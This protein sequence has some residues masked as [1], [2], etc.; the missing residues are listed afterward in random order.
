MAFTPVSSSYSLR[1]Q[2]MG[3]A[4]LAIEDETTYI[5][6]FNF[7]NPAGLS[8]LPHQD[9]LDLSFGAAIQIE[10]H[11]DYDDLLGTP[12]GNYH[13]LTLWFGDEIDWGGGAS[14]APV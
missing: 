12:M 4:D 8:Y 10:P 2:A 6:L 3:N 7:G 13:G 9:R 1:V 11:T 5:N 14:W